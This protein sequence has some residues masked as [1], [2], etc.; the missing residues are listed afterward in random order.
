VFDFLLFVFGHPALRPAALTQ[1]GGGAL[2]PSLPCQIY[3]QTSQLDLG[4]GIRGTGE[5]GE[6]R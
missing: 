5:I 1:M 3:R 2:S 4:K 6:E